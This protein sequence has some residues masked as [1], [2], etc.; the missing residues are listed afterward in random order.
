MADSKSKAKTEAQVRAEQHP[1]LDG[2]PALEVDERSADGSDGTRYVK[3]FVVLARDWPARDE[4]EA[5]IA[6]KAAVSNEAI[7]RGLHPRG[8]ATF[9][10]AEDHPDG[11]SLILTYSVDTVPAIVDHAPEDTTTPRDILKANGH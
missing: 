2:A 7:Q 3:Q 1:A 8:E 11:L 10:G 5:H 4:D 6:G 9:D